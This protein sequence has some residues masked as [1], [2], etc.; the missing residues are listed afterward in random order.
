MRRGCYALYP[1]CPHEGVHDVLLVSGSLQLT[2][3]LILTSSS[4]SQFTFRLPSYVLRFLPKTLLRLLPFLSFLPH[5]E[6]GCLECYG[7]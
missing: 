7:P 4:L 2:P 6:P 3:W 1:C 5:H